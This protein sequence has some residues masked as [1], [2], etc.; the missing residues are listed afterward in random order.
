MFIFGHTLYGPLAAYLLAFILSFIVI[1]YKVKD[2]GQRFF[3]L[4]VGLLFLGY[5]IVYSLVP[6]LDKRYMMPPFFLI[7][8][9]VVAALFYLLGKLER[10]ARLAAYLCLLVAAL[11]LNNDFWLNLKKDYLVFSYNTQDNVLTQDPLVFSLKN[12]KISPQDIVLAPLADAQRLN[13]ATGLTVIEEPD[14][15]K[16]LLEPAEFFRRYRIRYSLVDVSRLLPPGMIKK[17][18][19]AGD[20]VLFTINLEGIKAGK[21]ELF[22]RSGLY[23]DEISK[24]LSGGAR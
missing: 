7:A 19:L 9:T 22:V 18:E 15:L 20:R 13:F 21:N 2:S 16:N 23:E 12:R 5:S 14:N 1:G 17:M 6:V 3:F 10:K 24:R 8:L 11:F 4:N